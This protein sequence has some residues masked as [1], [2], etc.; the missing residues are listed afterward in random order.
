[1]NLTPQTFLVV[2]PLVFLAGFVDAIG[3]G[4]GLISL[5]AYL[6]AGVPIHQAIATNKLSSACGTC[7]ATI[8]FIRKGLVNWKLALPTILLAIAI[9]FSVPCLIGYIFYHLP[10]L[11]KTQARE[12][13]PSLLAQINH[14]SP[15][16]GGY[17]DG[18]PV[19]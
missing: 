17:G 19:S 4:G 12:M 1:M 13:K 5:P 3:G 16:A 6:I 8:R 18:S 2:C 11:K 9:A 14:A 15:S 10:C 7:L